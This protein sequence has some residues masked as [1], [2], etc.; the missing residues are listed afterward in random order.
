MSSFLADMRVL[1]T[2]VKQPE[3]V[4]KP[5]DYLKIA[6]LVLQRLT[7]RKNELMDMSY[8]ELQRMHPSGIRLV[9][10]VHPSL[11]SPDNDLTKIRGILEIGLGLKTP[12]DKKRLE[13][14]IKDATN[15]V[16]EFQ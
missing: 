3:V 7:R 6:E 2:L 14:H 1:Q 10:P 5:P 8:D 16:V 13:I 11:C 12:E 4:A 9:D 15:W